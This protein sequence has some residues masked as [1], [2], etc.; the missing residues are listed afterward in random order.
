M[1]I[2]PRD[3]FLRGDSFITLATRA[4]KKAHVTNRSE[5][6]PLIESG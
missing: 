3:Y 6:Q 4:S 5:R 1:S 2:P